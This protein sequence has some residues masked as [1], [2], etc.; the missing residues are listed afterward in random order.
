M[1][2]KLTGAI[3]SLLSPSTGEP[4][5]VSESDMKQAEARA[6]SVSVRRPS[7]G[8]SVASTISPARL[9]GVLRNVTEGNATDYFILAEEMEERDLHYSSV[10]RTRK[11]TVAGIPP[12]VEAASDDEHDVML[13]D[14]VRDLIEQPQIPSCCLT[15]LTDWAKAWVSAKSSGTPVMAGNP[16]T[17]NG[18]TRVSSK[19]TARPFASSAC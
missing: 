10:L 3:R 15:C 6:G 14:A 9:A 11:L 4:V 2:K 16:A 8:I 7:P 13:A 5:T 17:T 12:A 1:L 18:L 19:L